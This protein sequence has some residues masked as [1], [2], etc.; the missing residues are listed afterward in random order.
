MVRFG[1]GR[2]IAGPITK[3]RWQSLVVRENGHLHEGY[4]YK[5]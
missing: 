1:G 3:L 5:L 2:V 4:Q